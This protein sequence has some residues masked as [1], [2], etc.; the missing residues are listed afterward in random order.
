MKRPPLPQLLREDLNREPVEGET[1]SSNPLHPYWRVRVRFT[2][3]LKPSMERIRAA[4]AAQ[5]LEFVLARYPFASRSGSEV[6]GR[7]DAESAPIDRKAPA[8]ELVPT[9]APAAIIKPVPRPKSPPASPTPTPMTKPAL[10]AGL[11]RLPRDKQGRAVL[12]EDVFPAIVAANDGG[13]SWPVIADTLGCAER[14][15]RERIAKW[16]KR[17]AASGDAGEALQASVAKVAEKRQQG[18]SVPGRVLVCGGVPSGEALVPTDAPVDPEPVTPADPTDARLWDVMGPEQRLLATRQ[19]SA[20]SCRL[21]TVLAAAGVSC[22][23]VVSENQS[24]TA[25]VITPTKAGGF[26]IQITVNPVE[27]GG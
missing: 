17:Q 11:K 25:P 22:S 1:F 21:M 8:A 13:M 14:N 7:W 20:L 5:A 27:S 19:T 10:G 16:K 4:T 24:T 12:S 26:T 18:G 23:R 9:T 15:M 6:L 3:G 2:T